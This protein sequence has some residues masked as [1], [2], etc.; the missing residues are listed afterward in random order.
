MSKIVLSK[1]EL[2]EAEGMLDEIVHT[3]HDV[4]YHRYVIKLND[5]FY[6]TNYALS[7]NNGVEEDTFKC[8]EVKPVEVVTVNYVPV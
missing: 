6:E 8:V 2:F 7:Y 5:K 4:T 3:K 1:E